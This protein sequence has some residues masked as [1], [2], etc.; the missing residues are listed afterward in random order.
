MYVPI[1]ESIKSKDCEVHDLLIRLM[2]TVGEK[3]S[4]LQ[5]RF[6]LKKIIAKLPTRLGA[7]VVLSRIWSWLNLLWCQL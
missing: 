6:L 2:S 7:V 3:C 1:E 4:I 5:H